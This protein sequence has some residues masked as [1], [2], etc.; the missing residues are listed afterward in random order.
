MKR[1]IAEMNRNILRCAD[2]QIDGRSFNRLIAKN[3]F[4]QQGNDRREC[5]QKTKESYSEI[6]LQ[7]ADFFL[8]LE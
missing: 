7:V 3:V 5:D 8:H 2:A 1:Q 6:H 4:G